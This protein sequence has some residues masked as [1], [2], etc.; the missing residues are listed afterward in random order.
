MQ[1]SGSGNYQPLPDRR[2]LQSPRN[3]VPADVSVEFSSV[4]D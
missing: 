4:E 2:N 1:P 3:V